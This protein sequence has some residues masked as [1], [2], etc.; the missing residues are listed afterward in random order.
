[1]AKL[2]KKQM[3]NKE[4]G[5]KAAETRRRNRE[6]ANKNHEVNPFLLGETLPS[7]D[8]CN[9]PKVSS[10]YTQPTISKLIEDNKLGLD[11]TNRYLNGEF[12]YLWNNIRKLEE[13]IVQLEA[14]LG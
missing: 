8:G 2:T 9:G 11:S 13:R 10:T 1:M 5:R 14:R 6:V 3:M 7:T 12:S 4:R